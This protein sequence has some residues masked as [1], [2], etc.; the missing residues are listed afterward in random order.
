[1]GLHRD[2]FGKSRFG[3][4]KRATV[5]ERQLRGRIVN[6]ATVKFWADESFSAITAEEEMKHGVCTFFSACSRASTP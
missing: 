6:E 2:F 4:K 1:M 3:E 5:E